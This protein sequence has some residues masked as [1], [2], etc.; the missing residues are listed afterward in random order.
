[1]YSEIVRLQLIPRTGSSLNCNSCNLP[2]RQ[3]LN[4]RAG[5][6]MVFVGGA[7]SAGGNARLSAGGNLSL[8]AYDTGKQ[9]RAQSPRDEE[10]NPIGKGP[11]WSM[12][13]SIYNQTGVSI[14]V[15]GSLKASAGK[16][17]FAQGVNANVG[18]AT[19]LSAVGDMQ[20]TTA[21]N[22]NHWSRGG[23]VNLEG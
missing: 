22:G 18:G 17:L 6:D 12:E 4:M 23:A 7:I 2:A 20:L 13:N 1:M 21:L 16:N 9:I 19:S 5:G 3:N 15:G 11:V 14:D 8:I 10:G